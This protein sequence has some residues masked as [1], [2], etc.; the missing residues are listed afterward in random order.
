[1]AKKIQCRL[2]AWLRMPPA[3]TP[4]DVPA[5]PAKLWTPIAFDRSEAVAKRARRDEDPL[6]ANEVAE[7]S[8][9]EFLCSG[10]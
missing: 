9:E 8:G 1:L 5:E 3:I 2:M 6:A 10:G 4:T 7:P